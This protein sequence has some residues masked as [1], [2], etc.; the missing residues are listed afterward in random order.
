MLDV[1]TEYCEQLL[2]VSIEPVNVITNIAFAFFALL[3]FYKLR[4]EPG[5]LKYVLPILLAFVGVGS[6]WWHLGHTAS[7]DAADTL[8][9]II[10][11]SIVSILLLYKLLESKVKVIATF[12]PLLIITLIVE[13]LP[14]LN[15]S[16]PYLVLLIGLFIVGVLYVKKY[17]ASKTLVLVSIA[18]FALAIFSEV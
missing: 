1:P 13:Q 9:I 18:T 12:I 2:Y 8:F 6:V 11:S 17:P 16:L 4:K 15:G 3:A 5:S 7:G 14:Y 10:F